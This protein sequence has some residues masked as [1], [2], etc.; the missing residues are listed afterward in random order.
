VHKQPKASVC[1]SISKT[2]SVAREP[3]V[4]KIAK[5]VHGPNANDL[6]PAWRISSLQMIDPYGWHQI[7]RAK[8]QEI[9]QK[10]ASFEAMTWTEILVRAKK[11]NH[12]VRRQDLCKAAQDHLADI[13][14]DDVDELIS[15]RLSGKER[16]WGIRS[17]NVLT[18]LWWDPDHEVCPSLK[19]HT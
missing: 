17:H 3:T 16:V 18:V 11:Q 5:A 15:L 12:S 19:K 1:P 10:L 7:D 13:R 8:M 4:D 2:P 6:Q 14:L 9:Q